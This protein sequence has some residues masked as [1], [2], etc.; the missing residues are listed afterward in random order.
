MPTTTEPTIIKRY[1][2]VWI[3]DG[4]HTHIGYGET[5]EEVWEQVAQVSDFDIDLTK[6]RIYERMISIPLK[7]GKGLTRHG[8]WLEREALDGDDQALISQMTRDNWD[9]RDVL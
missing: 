2:K 6:C 5:Y 3:S 8:Y 9:W 1:W 7:E 4:A